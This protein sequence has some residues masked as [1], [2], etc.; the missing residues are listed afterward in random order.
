MTT[1][2]MAD[3]NGLDMS[4]IDIAVCKRGAV[5]VD[6][7]PGWEEYLTEHFAEDNGIA[8]PANLPTGLYRWTDYK[9]GSWSEDEM[10]NISGGAWARYEP[11]EATSVVASTTTAIDPAK[12][13]PNWMTCPIA[14]SWESCP[15]ATN[16]CTTNE[17][18]DGCRINGPYPGS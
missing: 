14:A 1:A 8:V 3:Q 2:I 6:Y 11:P 10:V 18:R 9:I 15:V 4:W 16:Q 13:L 5:I 7:S 12:H 17:C